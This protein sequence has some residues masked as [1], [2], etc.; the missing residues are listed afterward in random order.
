[1]GVAGVVVVRVSHGRA[2]VGI[3]SAGHLGTVAWSLAANSIHTQAAHAA[4]AA[5]RAGHPRHPVKVR[6]STAVTGP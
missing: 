5:A 4:A 2:T 1:M 3:T 6:P